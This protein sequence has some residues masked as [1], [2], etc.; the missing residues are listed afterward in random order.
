M[1]RL[2]RLV[3]SGSL[4]LHHLPSLATATASFGFRIRHLGARDRETPG[5]TQVSSQVFLPDHSHAIF[6][7]R[8]PLTISRVMEAI[9]DGATKRIN[10]S[11]RETGRLSQ[12]RKAAEERK[13]HVPL[14]YLLQEINP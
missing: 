8:H 9:K 1:S 14:R 3:R 12:P 11:R 2:R 4:V 10:H 6:H 7:P 13:R 5:P